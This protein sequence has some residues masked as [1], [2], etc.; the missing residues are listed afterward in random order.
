MSLLG[1]EVIEG[2]LLAL[3]AALLQLFEERDGDLCLC[4]PILCFLSSR[5][6]ILKKF[7]IFSF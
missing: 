2:V 5:L 4:W 7:R 6:T 1:N 3:V